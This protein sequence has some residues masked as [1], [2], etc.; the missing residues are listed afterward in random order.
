MYERVRDGLLDVRNRLNDE[1]VMIDLRPE[2]TGS[3]TQFGTVAEIVKLATEIP[4][5]FPC[6]DFSHLHA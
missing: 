5:V 3:P 2:T 6:I 4:G 1:G